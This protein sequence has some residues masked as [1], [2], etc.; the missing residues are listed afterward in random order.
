M[1]P[2]ARSI[3]GWLAKDELLIGEGLAQR[4]LRRDQGD[5]ARGHVLGVEAEGIAGPWSLAWYMAE[6]ALRSRPSTSALS[7]GVEA[8]ADARA[9]MQLAAIDG[10]RLPER[11]DQLVSDQAGDHAVFHPP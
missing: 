11:L 9:D 10:E 5:G 7:W 4:E 8:D 3:W 2:V 6:S 1:R